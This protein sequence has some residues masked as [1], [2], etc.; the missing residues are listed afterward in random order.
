MKKEFREIL[1]EKNLTALPNVLLVREDFPAGNACAITKL[2][3]DK[4]AD[5][6]K[7]HAAAKDIQRE[8]AKDTGPVQLHPG[9]AAALGD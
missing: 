8:K 7:V 1:R 4:K 5:L 2:I 9:A 6:E 3:Y